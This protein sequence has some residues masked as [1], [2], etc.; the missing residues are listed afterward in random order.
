MKSYKLLLIIFG[1]G[2]LMHSQD[3][4]TQNLLQQ[5]DSILNAT[6]VTA[7]DSF[8]TSIQVDT[9][10][11]SRSEYKK[12]LTNQLSTIL[13][14]QE[15]NSIGN[16][17]SVDIEDAEATLG[18]S[19]FLKS[20]NI[21]NTEFKG[22]VTDGI[23]P[24]FSDNTLNTNI[25]A[26]VQYHHIDFYD[27]FEEAILY[28][29]S[30]Q[31]LFLREKRKL[32]NKR[33]SQEANFKKNGQGQILHLNKLVLELEELYESY[34][35]NVQKRDQLVNNS[36]TIENK[37]L[38]K[39]INDIKIE[40][41]KKTLLSSEIKDDELKKK[42][43]EFEINEL[44]IANS[45]LRYE[46]NQLSNPELKTSILGK[47][48]N[49]ILLNI[50]NKVKE[51][52][53][54]DTQYINDE[55][56]RLQEEYFTAVEKLKKEMNLASTG[57]SISWFSLGYK[58]RNDAFR[59]YDASMPFS[60]QITKEDAVSHEVTAQ[61]S[62]Y[63]YIIN[64]TWKNFYSSVGLKGNFT[65]NLS[66]L[67]SIN[68]VDENTQIEEGVS[69]KTSKTTKAF[70]GE[71]DD[72]V[73]SLDV[74]L[75]HYHFLYLNKWALHIRPEHTI[76]RGSKPISNFTLGLLFSFKD[77][78]KEKKSPVNVEAFYSFL[79]VFKNTDTDLKLFERNAIGLKFTFPINFNSFSN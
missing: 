14:G 13:S 32:L 6:Q 21:I 11:L 52:K 20:G 17:A 23:S 41:K 29:Q 22:G 60:S 24:I 35:L 48:G 68:V 65:N 70:T 10:G 16:Y 37:E 53:Q 34:K 42:T 43:L 25:S 36:K 5:V 67:T 3:N 49:Q 19:L 15:A 69:R 57:L 30:K 78:D 63:R 62:W 28:N 73:R 7:F 39:S 12:A 27:H 54:V 38:K 2:Q 72:D 50:A 47:K 31:N 79:D 61:Y 44:E 26:E 46:L 45:K 18:V 56:Y 1:I 71:F 59:L 55:E 33:K 75:D 9:I 77:K 51:I 74:F 8:N 40:Q 4:P 58:V 66:G 64:N 76:R